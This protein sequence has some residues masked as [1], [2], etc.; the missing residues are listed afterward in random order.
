MKCLDDRVGFETW[1]D[2]RT[3]DLFEVGSAGFERVLA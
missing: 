1:A 3:P 2:L